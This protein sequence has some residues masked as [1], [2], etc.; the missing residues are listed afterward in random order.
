MKTYL[1]KAFY[2]IIF[3]L[4][5]FIGQA[6]TAAP[7]QP[8]QQAARLAPVDPD[9]PINQNISIFIAFALLYGTYVIYKKFKNKKASI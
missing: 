6:N 2:I 5:C 4:F 8:Q 7:P 3:L 1:N 9:V